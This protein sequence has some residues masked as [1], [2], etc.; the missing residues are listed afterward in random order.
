M[1]Q[2]PGSN[3]PGG[4]SPQPPN[5]PP[6]YGPPPYVPPPA[7]SPP[8]RPGTPWWVWVLGGCAGCFLIA[9]VVV[10]VSINWLGSAVRSTL[11]IP[12]T[13]QT[14]RQ[15]LGSDVP[16]YPGAALDTSAT[17]AALIALRT[18]E[19]TTGQRDGALFRGV[20]I[21]DTEDPP[22]RVRAFY[23]KHLAAQGWKRVQ[24]GSEEVD[25]RKGEDH[26]SVDIER[27]GETT[28]IT[29]MRG[30]KEMNRWMKNAGE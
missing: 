24:D 4:W 29:L 6:G 19:K 3:Q 15:E 16:L 26:L 22:D 21:Y 11:N 8:P 23:E 14:V 2:V 10:V 25:Y 18:M 13:L 1:S 7:Y 12:V 17:R 27:S 9:I 5:S 30:G 28:T 20:G